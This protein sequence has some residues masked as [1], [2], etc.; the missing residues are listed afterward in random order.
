V[1]IE[2][3]KIC[4]KSSKD[5][6]VA[7]QITKHEK[8]FAV[9]RSVNLHR[10]VK[11]NCYQSFNNLHHMKTKNASYKE[12][13]CTKDQSILHRPLVV[14]A[15]RPATSTIIRARSSWHGSRGEPPGAEAIQAMVAGSHRAAGPTVLA[16]Q[17][18]PPSQPR[19]S[20]PG[21]ASLA[22]EF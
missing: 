10:K 11:N 7:K 1:Y 21:P 9:N 6:Q 14:A 19:S 17:V 3:A 12:K 15:A 16:V 2:G 5:L 13:S 18:P 22:A 8:I 4:Y 20:R